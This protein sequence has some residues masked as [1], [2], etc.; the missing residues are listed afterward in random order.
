MRDWLTLKNPYAG[1]CRQLIYGLLLQIDKIFRG[2]NQP[3][4]RKWSR[5]YSVQ[6]PKAVAIKER[7][8]CQTIQKR[9]KCQKKQLF[10]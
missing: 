7:I 4:R 2:R 9:V 10:Y 3:V 5:F 8:K 6:S 1:G